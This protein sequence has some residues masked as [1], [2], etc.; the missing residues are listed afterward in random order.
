M[1]EIEQQTETTEE[2]LTRPDVVVP[3][4]EYWKDLGARWGIHRNEW[5]EATRDVKGATE[6]FLESEFYAD[7]KEFT[8]TWYNKIRQKIKEMS[9]DPVANVEETL[10]TDSE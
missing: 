7:A 10:P 4:S 5:K 3:L 8:I 2:E 9:A 6:N 1:D